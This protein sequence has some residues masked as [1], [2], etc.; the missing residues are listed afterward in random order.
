MERNDRLVMVW[1][2]LALGIAQMTLSL[3]A[4]ITC[5]HRGPADP[6]TWFYVLLAGV[7]TSFSFVLYRRRKRPD[8]EGTTRK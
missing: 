6:V 7:C 2:R 1:L 5:L 4:L 3:M 8:L